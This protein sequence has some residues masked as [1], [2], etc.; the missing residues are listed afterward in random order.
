M[1]MCGLAIRLMCIIIVGYN[2]VVALHFFFADT[3]LFH[4]VICVFGWAP[5]F[6]AK[7]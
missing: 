6:K 2:V 3:S 7:S 1:A 4:P 5:K